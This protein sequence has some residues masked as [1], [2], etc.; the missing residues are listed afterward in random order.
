MEKDIEV[1]N[2]D[3]TGEQFYQDEENIQE[4]E[5]TTADKE[6]LGEEEKT[7]IQDIL[8]L[9]KDNSR[10]ELKHIRTENITGTNVLKKA[11][12][13]YVG[14]KI[15][16]KACGNNKKKGIRAWWKRRIKKSINNVKK[17]IKISERHQRGE[18]RRQEKYDELERKYNIKNKE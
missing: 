16:L 11:V 17:H 4:N 7:M 13:V 5:A 12:I 9:M 1:N 8:D 14:K 6:N 3:N 2:N 18:I 10:I 15:G